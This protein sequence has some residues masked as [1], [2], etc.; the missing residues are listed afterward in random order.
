MDIAMRAIE[1]T[2]S[3]DEHGQLHLDQCSTLVGPCRVRIL[4]LFEEEAIPEKEW[5]RA[6]VK[7]PAFAFLND[8]AAEVYTAVDGK[9]FR[10]FGS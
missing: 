9:P 6:A 8:P 2:G 4:L 10:D 1:L 7:N 3:I 5:L